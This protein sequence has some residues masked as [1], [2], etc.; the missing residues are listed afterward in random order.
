[1]GHP[2]AIRSTTGTTRC[3]SRTANHL[4]RARSSYHRP[5]A[6]QLV[7]TGHA[8]R[9]QQPFP[10]SSFSGPAQCQRHACCGGT[11]RSA[12]NSTGVCNGRVSRILLPQR[13]AVVRDA[14]AIRRAAAAVTAA[15]LADAAVWHAAAA[16]RRASAAAAA[17]RR[18]AT[19]AAVATATAAAARRVAAAAAAA[20]AAAWLAACRHTG[21]R[22]SA[23][24]EIQDKAASCGNDRPR[25]PLRWTQVALGGRSAQDP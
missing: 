23:T 20:A 1:M 14:A 24:Q 4:G 19:A 6:C 16:V 2:L 17:I 18:A 5:C 13:A 10:S 22:S 9:R 25:L 12:S 7:H 11:G 21:W 8:V 15:R 3:V